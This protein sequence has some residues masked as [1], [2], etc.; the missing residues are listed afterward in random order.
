MPPSELDHVNVGVRRFVDAFNAEDLDALA[1][2]V[3]ESIEI[4]GRRGLVRG[5]EEAREWATRRPSGELR[6]RLVVDRV[7]G[8]GHPPVALLRRQWLWSEDGGIADEEE[9][10]VLVTLDADGLI[11][12]WQ[13]FEDP[14]EALAAAGLREAPDSQ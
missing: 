5:R 14:A 7:R 4:Q 13:P 9:V 10:A 8:D 11:C 2:A 3:S 12:R 1:G 6:Q